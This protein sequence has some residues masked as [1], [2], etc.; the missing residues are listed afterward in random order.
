MYDL[1]VH[2]LRKY[3]KTQLLAL[4]IQSDYVD[5]M[6]GHTVDTYRDIQSLR[7]DKL[8]NIYAASDLCIRQKTQ[9]NKLKRLRK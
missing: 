8:R 2:S 6:R 7:I 4:D 3:F 1:R 5:Y 9:V